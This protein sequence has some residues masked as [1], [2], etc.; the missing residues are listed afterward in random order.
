MAIVVGTSIT[1]LGAGGAA[2]SRGQSIRGSHI[3]ALQANEHYG[4]AKLRQ[5]WTWGDGYTTTSTSYG[6]VADEIPIHLSASSS[7]ELLLEIVG[8]NIRCQVVEAAAGP[9]GIVT[10]SAASGPTSAVLSSPFSG[11]SISSDGTTYVRINA[12]VDTAGTGTLTA[13]RLYEVAHDAA[14]IT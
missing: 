14:S 1:S 11:G 10:I 7:D 6:V 12:R 8:D 13:V 9:G 3:R 2:A 4:R 5:L